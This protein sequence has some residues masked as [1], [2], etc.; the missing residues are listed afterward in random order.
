MSWNQSGG[1]NDPWGGRQPDDFNA[2]IQKIRQFL[3][4]KNPKS[5]GDDNSGEPPKLPIKTISSVVLVALIGWGL[6]GFYQIENAE[7]GVVTRFGKFVKETTEGLNWHL[8]VPIEQVEVV[9]VSRVRSAE[10]GFRQN[11][12]KVLD[13]ALML[14]EDENIIDVQLSVQYQVISAKDY[15]FNV[16]DPE[17]TLREITESAL[18]EVVGRNSMDNVLTEGREQV[19]SEVKTL[20]QKT[21]NE[22]AT[23]LLVY[24]VNMRDASA[25]Q[26]VQAAFNDA[27]KAREDKE[28]FINEAQAYSNQIL[29]QARGEAARLK[30]ESIAYRERVIAESTGE[31]HRFNSILVAYKQAPEIMR[32]RLYLQTLEKV[33]HNSSKVIL[34]VDNSNNLL[35]LPLNNL[36]SNSTQTNNIE[37]VIRDAPSATQNISSRLNNLRQNARNSRGTK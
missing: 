26:Q 12:N 29:P 17:L 19:A 37:Q 9:N 7:R 5:D 28:R 23:G 1:P 10:I 15:A 6:S 33:F 16:R 24:T 35:Y 22:Y 27:V 8:P 13:E 34:D 2:F 4:D 32:E 20:V 36:I 25:P 30:E 3:G 31:A 18:R 14:T 11:G 21:L